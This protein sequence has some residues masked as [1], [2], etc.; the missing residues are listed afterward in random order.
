MTSVSL[1]SWSS[2][3]SNLIPWYRPNLW[4]IT[5]P[6]QEC[7]MHIT[8][9]ISHSDNV[10]IQPSTHHCCV[11][12]NRMKW[13][14]ALWRSTTHEWIME[15]KPRAL[16]LCPIRTVVIMHTYACTCITGFTESSINVLK[17]Q[18][19]WSVDQ[20]VRLELIQLHW[21]G[22]SSGDASLVLQCYFSYTSE[23][24]RVGLRAVKQAYR[25]LEAYVYVIWE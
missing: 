20:C 24:V 1:S 15:S 2:S 21:S 4:T 23:L 5:Y 7:T 19:I 17:A 3:T 13:E 16:S 9:S 14:A 6:W 18:E 22:L 8:N 11:G 12:R 25:T 10:F